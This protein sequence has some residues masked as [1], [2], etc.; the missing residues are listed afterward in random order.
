MRRIRRA[1]DRS[2]ARFSA[3]ASRLRIAILAAVFPIVC[4]VAAAGA[5]QAPSPEEA[6]RGAAKAQACGKCHGTP[7]RAPT[8]D[9]PTLAGQQSEFLVAQMFFLREGLRDVPE[10][11][12]I[13]KGLTDQDLT[14][15]AGYFA[16]QAPPR[17]LSRPDPKLFT[18]GERISVT[19]G[20]GSCHFSDYRGQRQVPRLTNLH[21]NFLYSTMKAYRNNKRVGVDTNMNAIL[22]RL[23]DSD[24]RALA[25][26][27]AHYLV[28]QT[29]TQ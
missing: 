19:M 28:R 10:M 20:C 5:A 7:D 27:L 2:E 22:A 25:H 4:I 13:L 21:E 9:A 3:G 24:I 18:L 29:A 8:D 6:A 23:P 17:I 26:Y 11:A 1:A 16:L 14:D 12:G 15:I